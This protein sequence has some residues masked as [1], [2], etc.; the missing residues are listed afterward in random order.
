MSWFELLVF[1]L[2]GLMFKVFKRESLGNP[3]QKMFWE[4]NVLVTLVIVTYLQLCVG[5]FH[6]CNTSNSTRNC[7]ILSMT[8]SNVHCKTRSMVIFILILKIHWNT[9]KNYRGLWERWHKY[10]GG[11]VRF[12][13]FGNQPCVECGSHWGRVA[14]RGLHVGCRLHRRHREVPMVM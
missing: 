12:A 13:V 8:S 9:S 2:A 4:R 5:E 14:F 7:I 1:F 3:P 10:W 6:K 11:G